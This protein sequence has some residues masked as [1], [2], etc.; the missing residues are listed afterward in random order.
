M[1]RVTATSPSDST[2]KSV[3]ATCPFGKLLLGSGAEITGAPGQVILDGVVPDTGRKSVTVNA[4]E[5]EGAGTSQNWSITAYAICAPKVAGQQRVAVAGTSSSASTRIATVNCPTGKSVVGTYGAINSPNGQVV[6]DSLFTD[7]GLT[8]AN[9]AAAE[10][11]TGNTMNWSLTVYAVCASTTQ[12]VTNSTGRETSGGSASQ[13]SCLEGKLPTAAG[14]FITA[15]FGRI[16]LQMLRPG[17]MNPNQW[18][19]GSESDPFNN[20]DE[21]SQA[22]VSCPAGKHILGFGGTINGGEGQVLIDD[23][24]TNAALSRA[25][26]TGFEDTT[27]FNADWNVTACGICVSR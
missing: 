17:F 25:A 1:E 16:G 7:A 26:I 10:D 27:G 22:S 3:V 14:G 8:N 12:A 20:S 13:L 21:F 15:G 19:S 18:W 24:G 9:V 23:L 4:L 2:N 11:G 6:L 5:D